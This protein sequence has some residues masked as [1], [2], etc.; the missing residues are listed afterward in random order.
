MR[1][2]VLDSKTPTLSYPQMNSGPRLTKKHPVKIVRQG[3]Q[4]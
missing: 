1:P 2:K 3:T 4:F